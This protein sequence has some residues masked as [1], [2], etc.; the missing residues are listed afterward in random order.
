MNKLII[1]YF[2]SSYFSSDLLEK[3]VTDVSI[4]RLVEVKSI[5]TQPD[6]PVGRKQILTPTALKTVAQKYGL[7][8]LEIKNLIMNE[9]CKLKIENC[10]LCL[11]YAY[12]AIIPKEL[13][14]LPKYGFWCLHPS[15]PNTAAL[16]QWQ[17]P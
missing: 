8:I 1:A 3:I 15:L 9:N 12:G 14:T 4:N 17:Q 6:R 13:L 16:L 11:L 5:V 7:E 2:G 10:D